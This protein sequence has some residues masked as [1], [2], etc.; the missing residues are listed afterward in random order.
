MKN[1]SNMEKQLSIVSMPDAVIEWR[2][3]EQM[4]HMKEYWAFTSLNRLKMSYI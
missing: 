2:C 3:S 1:Q 4:F